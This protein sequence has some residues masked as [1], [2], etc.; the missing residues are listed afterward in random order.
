M[1]TK[2]KTNADTDGTMCLSASQKSAVLVISA[3]AGIFISIINNVKAIANT[4]SQKASNREL[5]FVSAI[6]FNFLLLSRCI[7]VTIG[8][9]FLFFKLEAPQN[10]YQSL[11]YSSPEFYPDECN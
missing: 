6:F 10:T 4:P 3:V 5:G 11:L 1:I 8:T 7:P 9:L 2:L